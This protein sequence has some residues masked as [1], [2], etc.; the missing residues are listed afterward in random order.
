[1]GYGVAPVAALAPAI[2]APHGLAVAAPHAAVDYY[3]SVTHTDSVRCCF[4]T[5]QAASAC[6]SSPQYLPEAIEQSRYL[7]NF[8]LREISIPVSS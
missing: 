6:L 1:L 4:Y 7:T 5:A 3:V 8:I 2:A